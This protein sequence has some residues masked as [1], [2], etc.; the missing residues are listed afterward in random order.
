MPEPLERADAELLDAYRAMLAGMN[1]AF[2]RQGSFLQAFPTSELSTIFVFLDTWTGPNHTF[3][4]KPLQTALSWAWSC[5]SALL[6]VFWEVDEEDSTDIPWMKSIRTNADISDLSDETRARD[7]RARSAARATAAALEGVDRVARG[8]AGVLTPRACREGRGLWN[9]SPG[10]LARRAEVDD[11]TIRQFEGN[12][13]VV[14]T[15]DIEDRIIATFRRYAV[16][17]GEGTPGARKVRVR[18][19]GDAIDMGYFSTQI[20]DSQDGWQNEAWRLAD[21]YYS[22][23]W[24]VEFDVKE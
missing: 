3:Q 5:A 15:K 17:V 19:S 22:R 2:L 7:S 8:G 23:D 4:D 1:F 11:D 20:E 12:Y 6:K 18:W 10:N 9:W 16:V 14:L 24:A 13:G 21:M